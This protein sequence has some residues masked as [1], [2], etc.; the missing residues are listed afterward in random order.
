MGPPVRPRR[1]VLLRSAPLRVRLVAGFALVMSAVLAAA[2]S[3][4]YWRVQV[5]LDRTLDNA[6]AAQ[7]NELRQA[8]HANPATAAAALAGLSGDNRIASSQVVDSTG[9]LLART[10]NAPQGSLLRHT[11]EL[12]TAHPQAE[13]NVGE[14]LGPARRRQRVLAYRMDAPSGQGHVFVVTAVPLAQRDEALRELLAQLAVANLAALAIASAVGYRLARA[15]LLPVDRYRS[16]AEQVTSGATGIRLDVPT[17]TDDEVTRL[18]HTLNRMLGAQ[19]QAVAAQRQ[20]LADASHELR[21]PLTILSGEVELA[22]RRPRTN[23]ELTRTLDEVAVDTRRLIQLANQLLDLEHA[24]SPA[25]RGDVET[26]AVDI[27]SAVNRAV[28][29][30]RALVGDCDRAV[31]AIAGHAIRASATDFQLDHL[32]GNLVDNAVLHGAGDITIRAEQITNAAGAVALR[33]AVHDQGTALRH[34][35]VPYAVDRFRREDQARNGLGSGLGLSLVHTLARTLGGEL[36][37]C[38]R[39]HHNT[40]QPSS[41]PDV[42]CAHDPDGTTV[43]VL[44]PSSTA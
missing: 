5:D 30:G 14:L 28:L 40:Y 32:L 33:L 15:A 9:L 24:G 12:T 38:T 3:F 17:G 20:F 44:L 25:V 36:R 19:E 2:G 1:I 39:G 31:D 43:T 29:R 26:L 23:E 35:F 34:A 7:A 4:V 37:M 27:Q 41:Y 8:L 42:P 21:T 11:E 6:L 10:D 18:G 16:Q 22:L 13:Y